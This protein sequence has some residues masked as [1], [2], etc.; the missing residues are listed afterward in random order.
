[1]SALLKA[2]EAGIT[3]FEEEFL[4]HLVMPGTGR[5]VGQEALPRIREA[6]ATGKVV[7]LL[8]RLD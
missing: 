3:V 4:A 2:V 7:P 8:P 1:M 5:T 6:Y